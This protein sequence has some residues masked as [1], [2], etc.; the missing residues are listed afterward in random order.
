LLG[1]GDAVVCRHRGAAEGAEAEDGGASHQL[2]SSVVHGS[3][4]RNWL[5]MGLKYAYMA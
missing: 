4:L 3:L 5:S 2:C 1:G